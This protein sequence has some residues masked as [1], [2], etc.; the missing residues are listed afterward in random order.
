MVQR[1]H[2]Q[3]DRNAVPMPPVSDLKKALVDLKV[4]TE[5]RVVD[6]LQGNGISAESIE[7]IQ[8]SYG[9]SVLLTD[10]FLKARHFWVDPNNTVSDEIDNDRITVIR[11]FE[12]RCNVYLQDQEEHSANLEVDPV[13]AEKGD[14]IVIANGI[15]FTIENPSDAELACSEHRIRSDVALR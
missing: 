12:G 4:P 8:H 14:V 7:S 11:I 1:L 10:S 13:I 15:Y 2:D 6:M 3:N 9:R 5:A